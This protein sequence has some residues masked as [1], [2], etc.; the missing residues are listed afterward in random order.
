M[1]PLGPYDLE[2]TRHLKARRAAVWRCW[3]EPALMEQWFCPRPWRATDIEIDL[4]P[5]GRFRSIIRG[6][7][8]EVFDN[9]P[10]CFLD[11]QPMDRLAWTSALGPGW[12]P[13]LTPP[14]GFAMT[15]IM[16]FRDA[17]EGGTIYHARALHATPEGK[18]AHE[19]MGFHDGWG[20]A[21]AQLDELALTL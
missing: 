8:G 13:V 19:A 6:P 12:R 1:E 18:T 21:A 5:G 7:E 15:A 3:T 2:I 11:V 9:A 16:T 10:G 14:E 20:A 17:P 4:R